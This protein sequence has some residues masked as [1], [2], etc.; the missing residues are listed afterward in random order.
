MELNFN[1]K[2]G[3]RDEAY[4]S[5]V[6]QVHAYLR[7]TSRTNRN[8]DI[9]NT[10]WKQTELFGGGVMKAHVWIQDASHTYELYKELKANGVPK[11]NWIGYFVQ[12]GV[13]REKAKEL[14]SKYEAGYKDGRMNTYN[15]YIDNVVEEIK[16]KVNTECGNKE[17]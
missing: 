16:T 17:K 5:I 14:I 13:G 2:A 12:I 4:K 7:R 11:S 3:S 9:Q 10:E 15:E 6:N 1:A 8:W